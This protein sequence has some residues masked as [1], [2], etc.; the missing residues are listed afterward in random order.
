MT[1]IEQLLLVSVISSASPT[2]NAEVL[3][4]SVEPLLVSVWS[5]RP[6]GAR[7]AARVFGTA[8][9]RRADDVG[10]SIPAKPQPN[11]PRRVRGDR[12]GRRKLYECTV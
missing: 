7:I 8:A 6:R 10:Q 3:R 5:G 9:A 12:P 1:F 2:S 11:D 4:G